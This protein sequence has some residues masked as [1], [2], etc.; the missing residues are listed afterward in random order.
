MEAEK[1]YTKE[2]INVMTQALQAEDR[3]LPQGLTM[4]NVYTEL[5]TSSKNAVVVVRNITAYPHT[6][7]KKMLVA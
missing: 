7:K 2:R 4:Q 3:L 5:K 6:L 1:V